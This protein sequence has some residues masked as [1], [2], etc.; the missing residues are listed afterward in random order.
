VEANG[1]ACF[2]LAVAEENLIHW[3]EIY[4]SPNDTVKIEARPQELEMRGINP[5]LFA[6]NAARP[7]HEIGRIVLRGNPWVEWTTPVDSGTVKL[8]DYISGI[9][10]K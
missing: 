2:A 3:A 9:L 6:Q 10:A 8:G 4:Y 5:K 1:G 7:W